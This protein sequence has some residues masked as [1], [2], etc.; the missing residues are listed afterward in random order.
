MD[1]TQRTKQNKTRHKKHKMKKQRY[2]IQNQ[3]YIKDT[4]TGKNYNHQQTCERLNHLE[5][6]I[7]LKT[8]LIKQQTKTIN[9]LQKNLTLTQ[10]NTK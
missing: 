8:E 1:N 7:Q 9:A 2:T 4:L 6:I 3:Y 10:N 5:R